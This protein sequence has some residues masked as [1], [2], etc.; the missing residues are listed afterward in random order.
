M[1]ALMVSM[2]SEKKAGKYAV[3]SMIGVNCESKKDC[4]GSGS[5]RMRSPY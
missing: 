5:L 4:F 1:D 2:K 3:Y